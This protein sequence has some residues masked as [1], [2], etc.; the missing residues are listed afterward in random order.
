MDLWNNRVWTPTLLDEIDKPF[1]NDN[2]LYEIKYD[3]IRA[4][5]FVSPKEF[6][7]RNRHNVD[8][9][10]LYPELKS[11]QKLVKK[12]T[13]LDG[14]IVSMKDGYPSFSSLQTRSHL[15]DKTKILLES[16]NNPVVFVAF[17][18]LYSDKN[19]ID[20]P[21]IKRKNI[22]DKLEN[23]DSLVKTKYTISNGIKLFKNIKK[24][25]L[26]GIVAK[27]INSIYE[28][29][30]RVKAWIKIKNFKIESFL[31]GGYEKK[32][33]NRI[34][35]ALGELKDNKLYYVGNVVMLEN[36][37]LYKSILKQPKRTTSPF[38]NHKN[39]NTTYITPKYSIL[40]SYMERTPNN[41]LRQPVI[42]NHD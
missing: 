31:I 1:N 8:M 41:H 19:L 17:D 15:K 11:I 42:K 37:P 18:I 40:V 10:H 20:L 26:E 30:K 22:L 4:I 23:N 33:G 21:L 16:I 36:N 28:I 29:N 12:K 14:E 13:I 6:Q 32:K 5:I 9:T 25:N 27:E 2:Y 3:G 39:N 38:E 34:S 35:I 7:I 24:L